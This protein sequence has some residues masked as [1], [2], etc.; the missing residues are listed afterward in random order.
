MKYS[1]IELKEILNIANVIAIEAHTGQVDK[2]GKPYFQHALTVSKRCKTLEGK[3]VGFLHDVLEDCPSWS[4]TKLI[5]RGIPAYLVDV[6]LLL[7]HEKS[8]T[9]DAYIDRVMTNKLAVEVKISDLKH[10]M[11][12][13][14]NKTGLTPKDIERTIKYHRNY[15]KLYKFLSTHD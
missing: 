6:V 13:T 2:T 8:E 5:E 7:T 11:D 15:V 14:R 4:P 10:N 9:Y 3:I 1:D 12:L